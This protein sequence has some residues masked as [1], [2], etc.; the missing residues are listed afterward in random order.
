[1]DGLTMATYLML[2]NW[3][4]QGIRTVKESPKRL[5]AA[6]KLAKDMGGDIR[7]VYLTQG[8][9]DLV[10]VVEMPS[11]EKLASLVLKLASYG[12]VRTTTLK[13][14][15]EDEYRKIIGGLN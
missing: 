13:A 12:N 7:T 1:M 15:S 6:R 4:D 9:V 3:T 14:Y 11:D 8:A 2:L 10:L 5:D